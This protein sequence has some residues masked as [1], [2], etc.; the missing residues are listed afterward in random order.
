MERQSA[1]W[2]HGTDHAHDFPQSAARPHIALTCPHTPLDK[3]SAELHVSDVSLHG[4][5]PLTGTC[6]ITFANPLLATPLARLRLLRQIKHKKTN[7]HYQRDSVARL[8]AYR[9]H[10]NDGE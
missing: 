7:D 9:N 8:A 5:T 10:A 6:T 2:Y 1:R 4:V 3:D